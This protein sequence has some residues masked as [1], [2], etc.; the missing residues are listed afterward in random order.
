MRFLKVFLIISSFVIIGIVIYLL[1]LESTREITRQIPYY[2][3][4][5]LAFAFITALLNIIFHIKSYH[6]YKRKEKRKLHKKVHKILWVATICFSCFLLYVG[7]VAL[8][9]MLRF[10]Q[11]GYNTRD[12]VT[13]LLFIIPGFLGFLEASILKKR[14]R[15]LRLEHNTMEEIENIGK[16]VDY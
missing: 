2:I 10:I 5:Y 1:W 7:G 13:I 11:Y 12:I 14:I 9:T 4:L 6:F 3:Y 8:Y 16:E 15:R